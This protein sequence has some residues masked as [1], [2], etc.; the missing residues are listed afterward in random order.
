LNH[1]VPP[2]PG[3]V[4]VFAPAIF[5]GAFLLFAV[6]PLMAKF[7]LPWFGGGPGVWTTC[8]LFF[9]ALLLAGYAYSHLLS[10]CQS[11]RVQVVTHLSLLLVALAFL[12]VAPGAHR[13]PEPDAEPISRILLLLTVC[14]GTPYLALAA[15]APLL[16]SWFSGVRPGVVPYRLYAVSSAGSL[17]ALLSYPFVFEPLLTRQA[18]AR[19]WALGFVLFTLLC[20]ICAWQFCQVAPAGPPVDKGR[21]RPKAVPEFAA[22]P[23]TSA[24]AWWFALPACGSVLLMATTNKLCMDVAAVPFLW[25]VP[26]SLYLLTFVISF[27]RPAWYAR[28]TCL[29]LLAVFSALLCRVMFIGIDAPLWQQVVSY[30]GTLLVGCLVCH[31]EVYRLRPS[32]A[33]LTS[34]YLWLAAGGAAGGLL[35]GVVSPLVFHS[36]AELNW[37]LW[38]LA[39]LVFGLHAREKTRVRILRRQWP[40]W[41]AL[42]AGVV[43][44]GAVLA[45]QSR[46][47]ARGSVSMTRNFYGVLRVAELAANTEHRAYVL[48]N[49]E[50]NHG[51]QLA[52]PLQSTIPT[53]YYNEAGGAGVTFNNFPRQTNRAVGLVGLGT[54][55]MAAYGNTGDTF[56]FYEINPEVRR[57]AQTGFSFLKNSA[58]HIEIVPGDARLTL[59]RETGRQFDLLVLDAFSGDSIPVHLLTREAFATYFRLLKSDG[60]ILVHVSN[61]HLDFLPVLTGVAKEFHLMMQFNEWDDPSRPFWFSSSK[62][63][64]LSRNQ[65]FMTSEAMLSHATPM[66]ENYREHSILWTDDYASLLPLFKR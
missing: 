63:V 22:P 41:P 66:S 20:G 10:R 50:I 18:Q 53:S 5:L 1:G 11:R 56:V 38:L 16:Q 39:A 54:G 40:L 15:T 47:A 23:T 7:I 37:G 4:K 2:G 14:L 61:R 26:L 62:W 64:M 33:H 45:Y 9:Q 17:L 32:A 29:V 52:D 60:V 13:K 65:P 36:F 42:L 43:V 31:G 30:G 28:R 3:E 6:Q 58:A 12:P 34:F 25:V 55:T 59:E 57:L 27:D 24:K 8:L 35:V 48:F 51:L 46:R 19:L 49:G 21:R 44:L